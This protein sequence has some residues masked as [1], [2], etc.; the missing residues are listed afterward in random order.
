MP[1]PQSPTLSAIFASGS[2]NRRD[3]LD[4]YL[5][6]GTIKSL[7]RG[8]VT[9]NVDGAPRVY[10]DYIRAV[11]DFVKTEKEIDRLS[12]TMLNINSELG[13]LAASDLRLFDYAV[14]DYGRIYQSNINPALVEDFPQV[15]RS[16]IASA[17]ITEAALVLSLI[18]DFESLPPTVASRGLK[19]KCIWGYKQG[20]ECTSTSN[21]LTCS[22]TLFA[23]RKRLRP[24]QFS[25]WEFFEEPTDSAPGSGGNSGGIIV[26]CF[27]LE[28]QIR[29]VSGSA[30]IG[31]LP[32]GKLREPI[33]VY[34][35]NPRTDE[36]EIDLITEVGEYERTGFYTLEFEHGTLQVTGEHPLYR[37]LNQFCQVNNWRLNDAAQFEINGWK[38]SRLLSMKWHGGEKITVRNFNVKKN[39]T[40]FANG[41]AVHNLKDIGS[42][43]GYDQY[44]T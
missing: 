10:Q 2:Y 12:I 5:A 26:G 34:S 29:L 41:C 4:L 19:E 27:S 3:T 30:A 31:S 21:Q 25:G 43:G 7:S 15:F 44:Q 16:V 24:Y 42:H 11:G 23:C 35:F 6:D 28:T 22:K 9:R 37:G 20:P 8:A 33:P 1:Q 18:T 17:A 36:I 40:Y 32:L 13:L 14:A 39:H 38:S